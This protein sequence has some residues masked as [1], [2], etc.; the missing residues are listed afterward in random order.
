[1]DAVKNFS[2]VSVSTGYDAI[3][4]TIVLASG[5]GAKLPDPAVANF[6]LV[7][8]DS[9]VYPDP[10]DDPNV[11]IVRCTAKSTDT[12]TVTRAQ[13]STSASTKNTGG[14]TYRMILSVTAKTITDLMSNP[15]TTS[16][17]IIYG[18]TSGAPTRLAKGTDAQVLTLASGLPS[19]A[20]V[21]GN[22]PTVYRRTTYFTGSGDITGLSF[23]A[24][25]GKKYL[26]HINMAIAGASGFL[27]IVT[28][29]DAKIS[30]FDSK[31]VGGDW[32]LIVSETT[33]GT[34]QASYV[35]GGTDSIAQLYT[36][37]IGQWSINNR[38]LVEITTGGTVKL[39]LSVSA[40]IEA[41]AFM[42]VQEVT[43]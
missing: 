13:E 28:P 14:S 17:D 29:S 24:I 9:S 39:S 30:S 36:D 6:N 23:T 43:I 40:T 26:I 31:S 32:S 21:G 11:E 7:W 20:S 34:T 27:Q 38:V 2:K 1:M 41:G 16:G 33:A 19:W 35:D 15:M 18:G 5:H 3:A 22:L 10:S 25:A 42:M 4:T 12:L 37:S 8:W